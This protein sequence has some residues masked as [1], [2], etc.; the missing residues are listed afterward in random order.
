MAEVTNSP[1]RQQIMS[2]ARVTKD[3]P[4]NQSRDAI[5]PNAAAN[6]NPFQVKDLRFPP[7]VSN[8]PAARHWVKFTPLLAQAGKWKGQGVGLGAADSNRMAANTQI[9][10]SGDP[11]E[12]NPFFMAAVGAIESVQA[13][14]P[15]LTGDFMN[16]FFAGGG[17]G[18][19]IVVGGLRV[20]ANFANILAAQASLQTAALLVKGAVA[21][22]AIKNIDMTRK[23][24]RAAA[25]I[26]L[27]MPDTVNFT[28]VNDYDQLSL[29]QALGKAGF[30]SQAGN[31]IV[32][33]GFAPDFTNLGGTNV[34]GG[35]L[36]SV[37][38][39]GLDPGGGEL[40]GSLAEQ[41]GLFGQGITDALLFSSG[42]ALNPQVELIFK[43]VQNR[44]FLFDFK[45]S[46]KNP[47]EAAAILEIIKAF[48]Y[49]SAPEIPKQKSTGRYL[50]PPDEFDIEFM[51]GDQPHPKLPK[52]SSC[53]LQGIDVNY[54]SAGQWTTF[55][56]GMPVEISLQLRFKEV[57]IMHKDLIEAG[58]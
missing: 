31:E 40:V 27:F 23:T 45:F 46:P 33:E 14:L 24:K 58:Y 3:S 20:R 11:L 25:S 48:R 52:I 1:I 19:R 54:A 41:S 15:A 39:T 4:G 13:G 42:Y 7:D 8:N 38:G 50:V 12:F 36:D 9:S 28:S 32:G 6:K 26:S 55:Y 53:V 18:S 57:E 10:G 51:F 2:D 37:S 56:D 5:G 22:I 47:Q 30:A 17:R 44:E 21:G 43:S 35:L 49:Y 16:G 29:T 34:V